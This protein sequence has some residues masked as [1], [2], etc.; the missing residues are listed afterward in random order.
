[1]RDPAPESRASESVSAIAE[2]DSRAGP[3]GGPTC[4]RSAGWRCRAS[5]RPRSTDATTATRLSTP[6]LSKT[7]V[8]QRSGRP[9]SCSGLEDRRPA[10]VWK[11]DVPQRSGRSTAPQPGRVWNR[12][13][14]DVREAAVDLAD[15]PDL[16]PRE[17]AARVADTR[18]PFVS[19]SGEDWRSVQWTDRPTN[20]SPVLKAHDP[21]TS[22]TS[23]VVKG[24]P[25]DRH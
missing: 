6:A 10:A 24:K 18:K 22:S 1:M 4:R 7:V 8:P 16:S 17:P 23:V 11:T 2:E 15:E 25:M 21:T 5:R 19:E 12:L 3:S 13:P 14:D 9:M 20:G